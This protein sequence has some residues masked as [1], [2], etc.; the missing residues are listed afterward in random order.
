MK[1]FVKIF[2]SLGVHEYKNIVQHSIQVAKLTRHFVRMLDLPKNPDQVYLAGLLHD[3]GLVFKASIENYELFD[4][5]RN[6]P[7]LITSTVKS[8]SPAASSNRPRS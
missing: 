4:A 2:S 3:V 5:F 6:I 7:D 8:G 1:S